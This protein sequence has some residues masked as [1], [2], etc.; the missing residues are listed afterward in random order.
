MRHAL[1]RTFDAA[2][3]LAAACVLA[4][5]VLMIGASVGRAM[6]WRVG[7]ANDIVAWLCAAAAFLAM[8]HAFKNGDFV[9]VTL[10]L[11]TLKPGP[12]RFFEIVSLSVAVVAVGYLAYWAARFTWE[13]WK[14]DDIAGGMVAIPMWIPQTSFVVGAVLF[15]L[16]IVDELV[17]VLRGG[18]P[19]YVRVV[20]ERHAQGDFSADL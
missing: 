7:A 8:A 12:R 13:S 16:A 15:W 5:L 18:E 9:R 4:I 19:T 10:L 11:E 20:A 2:A 6:G 14:F 17:I 3:Y 1:N